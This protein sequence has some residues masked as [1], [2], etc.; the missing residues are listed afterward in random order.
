MVVPFMAIFAFLFITDQQSR[1]K[2]FIWGLSV[3]A[4]SIVLQTLFRLWYFGDILPNTYYLKMTGFPLLLRVSRGLIVFF[5]FVWKMNWIVFAIPFLVL[6][7]R[8]DKPIL[9]MIWIFLAQVLYS[10]YVGGDAWE[11]WGGSNR[12]LVIVMP[13]LFVLLGYMLAE[14]AS[15][16]TRDRAEDAG[17][18][19]TPLLDRISQEAT[20]RA[21]YGTIVFVLIC[22]LSLNSIYG[23]EALG[24]WLLIKRPLLVLDNQYSVRMGSL[25]NRI[26]NDQARIAVGYAGAIP[27]FSGR[28]SIDLLG[29]TDKKIAREDM[30]ISSW[31]YTGFYPGHLK[32]NYSYSIGELKPDVIA[33]LWDLWGSSKEARPYLEGAYTEVEIEGLTL[34]LRNGSNNIRWSEIPGAVDH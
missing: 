34:Y 31:K 9:L 15:L 27:Y 24:E 6:L 21:T 30:R 13:V 3:L 32:W 11:W 17:S 18:F 7:F 2:H 22:L 25:L 33:Q 1:R 20:K 16:I 4:P 12:Y 29:K 14:I 26:T 8:R 19:H 23:P 10:V 28:N 5:E